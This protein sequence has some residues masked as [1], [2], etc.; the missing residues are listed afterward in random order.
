[1]TAAVGAPCRT[2]T[3]DHRLRRRVGY[4]PKWQES[5]Y[6]FP[7][8]RRRAATGRAGAT[9]L[10]RCLAYAVRDDALTVCRG[11]ARAIY[12]FDRVAQQD[13]WLSAALGTR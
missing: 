12:D 11:V 10:E 13:I 3:C 4:C 8:P 5:A 7:R 6:S 9:V 2:R 1:V